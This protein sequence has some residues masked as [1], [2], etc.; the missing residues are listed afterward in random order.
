MYKACGKVN[1]DVK[2]YVRAYLHVHKYTCRAI[3]G[4][5]YRLTA[6]LVSNVSCH[7]NIVCCG[8]SACVES[9]FWLSTIQ[10]FFLLFSAFL[11]I[12]MHII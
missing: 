11:C 3:C 6:E 12:Y 5:L 10:C 2:S 1:I 9:C 4:T 8:F 7:N